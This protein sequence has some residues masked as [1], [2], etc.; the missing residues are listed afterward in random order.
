[1]LG[2]RYAPGA[3]SASSKRAKT[4]ID[5]VPDGDVVLKVSK[6]ND[7]VDLRALGAVIDLAS[8]YLA[9]ALSSSFNEGT[10]KVVQL[11]ENDPKVIEDFCNIV[12]H[13]VDNLNHCDGP[14]ILG[15]SMMADARFCTKTLKPWV[16]TRLF[17]VM[18]RVEELANK[19]DEDEERTRIVDCHLLGLKIEQIVEIAA[20]FRM[21]DLFWHATR[22]AIYQSD[23]RPGNGDSKQVI[24]TMQS[25]GVKNLDLN[26]KSSVGQ[27]ALLISH[28]IQRCL[29]KLAKPIRKSSS[30]Q[31]LCVLGSSSAAVSY[32]NESGRSGS[33]KS[34]DTAP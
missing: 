10:S 30:M 33:A 6:G 8:E 28:V 16:A 7:V 21:E 24:S 26:G 15:P 13:K 12:H 9:K 27:Q 31:S 5:V 3:T 19:L 23:C 1:M 17:G 22:I 2:K 14:R 25:A 4:V 32:A 34:T 18:K 11:K 29:I 20:I